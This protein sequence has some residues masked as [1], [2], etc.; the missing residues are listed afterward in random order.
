MTIRK[1]LVCGKEFSA[2]PARKNAKLCSNACRY[3]WQKA[4]RKGGLNARWTGGP[5]SKTCQHCGKVFEWDGKPISTWQSQKFCSKVCVVAGQHRLRGAD[6]P[7]FQG[8]AVKRQRSKT[9]GQQA[10]WS[11]DV[12]SR[13]GGKCQRCGATGVELHAHHIKPWKDNPE[14]RWDVSNGITLCHR[15]HWQTHSKQ[16]EEHHA[17][18]ISEHGAHRTV[19][20][21]VTPDGRAYRRVDVPCGW[22]GKLVSRPVGRAK[23]SK[24]GLLF[25]C[26]SHSAKHRIH[27]AL[28]AGK[29]V[30]RKPSPR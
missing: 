16:P 3:L 2:V 12:I 1:C 8:D 5:R 28:A 23:H 10:K 19:S 30:G 27:A 9:T 26:K 7:R 14:A 15:C 4:A 11:A 29:T 21:G 18:G 13:D 6:H 20:E 22:C 24:S 17:A 25:C